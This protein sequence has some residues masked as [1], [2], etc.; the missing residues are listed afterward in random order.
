MIYVQETVDE[1]RRTWNPEKNRD[2]IDIFLTEI[3]KNKTDKDSQFSGKFDIN[4][5]LF[6]G[7]HCGFVMFLF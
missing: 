5:F 2:F 1:H 4:R 3:E 6:Y 7:A